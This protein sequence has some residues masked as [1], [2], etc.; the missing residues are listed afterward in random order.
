MFGPEQKAGFAY[1]AAHVCAY[2]M[3][4]LNLGVWKFKYI[5]HDWEKPW[6]MLI[7]KYILRKP[8]PY[9]WVQRW[10][11]THRK[12]HVQYFRHAMMSQKGR[13]INAIETIL[14]WEC[15]RFTKA[16]SGRTA[17][18]YYIAK[19]DT[20]PVTVQIQLMDALQQ[21]GLWKASER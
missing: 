21:L 5:F 16:A 6:L 18:E 11:R 9:K 19:K 1:T 4:A 8:E 3:T 15:S 14:D 20:F 2:N 13:S 10:H 12:H 7:A 17:Y